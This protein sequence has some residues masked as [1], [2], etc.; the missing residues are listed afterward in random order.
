VG[1]LARLIPRFA[2]DLDVISLK[3]MEQEPEERHFL[4]SLQIPMLDFS[5][6]MQS[7]FGTWNGSQFH[8]TIWLIDLRGNRQVENGILLPSLNN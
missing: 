7:L 4:V 1:S 5:N 2:A 3:G 6:D 8:S